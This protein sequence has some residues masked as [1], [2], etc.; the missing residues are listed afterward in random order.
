MLHAW[1]LSKRAGIYI[2]HRVRAG[3]WLGPS[4]LC[5]TLE[6]AVN[7][8][9]AVSGLRVF[10]VAEPSGGAPTLYTSQYVDEYPC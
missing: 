5:K 7:A 6:A 8:T 9:T 1:T 3:E 2:V 10:V 4:V